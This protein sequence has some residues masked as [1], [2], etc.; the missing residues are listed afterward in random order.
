MT[1]VGYGDIT[2]H[3]PL[4][5]FVACFVMVMGYGIIAVPTGIVSVELHQAAAGSRR[6]GQR[7]APQGLDQERQHPHAILRGRVAR[8]RQ[9]RRGRRPTHWVYPCLPMRNRSQML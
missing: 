7:Q 8:G 2:P 3:T 9:E 5:K 1:T 6:Q 4:G